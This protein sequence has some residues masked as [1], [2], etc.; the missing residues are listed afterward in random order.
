M[1]YA[2]LLRKHPG[3]DQNAHT[4]VGKPVIRGS[5]LTV[6]C[7]LAAVAG[8][9]SIEKAAQAYHVAPE[10]VTAALLYA[11]DFLREPFRLS[12]DPFF[13]DDDDVDDGDV[14]TAAE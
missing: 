5:R 12:D 10:V 9:G 2:R 7:L 1:D 14:L 8:E 13:D 6:E 3:I 11:K 4:M